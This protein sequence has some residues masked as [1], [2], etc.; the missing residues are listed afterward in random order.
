MGY[1]IGFFTAPFVIAFCLVHFISK[2]RYRKKHG[3]EMSFWKV[4]IK[5]III[6]IILALF[7]LYGAAA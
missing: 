5:T 3:E 7:T 6:G 2:R 1:F 4:L